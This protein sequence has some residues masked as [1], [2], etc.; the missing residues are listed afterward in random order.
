MP[1]L[2]SLMSS[3]SI[4]DRILILS[5]VVVPVVLVVIALATAVSV[6]FEVKRS[7]KDG[8]TTAYKK[9]QDRETL[10]AQ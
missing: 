2:I 5:M 8:Q 1:D 10:R 3:L 4:P 9:W 7:E 6:L